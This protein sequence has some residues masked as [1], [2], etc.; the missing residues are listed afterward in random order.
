MG[1]LAE[2]N[3]RCEKEKEIYLAEND[4]TV[5]ALG[6][7]ANAIQSIADAKPGAIADLLAV[8]TAVQRNPAL[9]AEMKAVDNGAKWSSILQVDPTDAEYKFHSGGLLDLLE[10]LQTQFTS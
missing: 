2:T 5:K 9:E 10:D 6:A 8:K 4:D 3:A 1:E 7:L